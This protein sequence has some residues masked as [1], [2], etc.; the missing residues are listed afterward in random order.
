MNEIFS[1]ASRDEKDWPI[2]SLSKIEDVLKANGLTNAI[3]S[4]DS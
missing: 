3:Q 2:V 4:G 1:D